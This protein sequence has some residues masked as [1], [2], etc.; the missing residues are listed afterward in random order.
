MVD[1]STVSV[2]ADVAAEFE[3]LND[4]RDVR[5]FE[6]GAVDFAD[7]GSDQLTGDGVASLELAFVLQLELPGN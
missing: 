3:P 2:E 5:A 1:E 7:G 4:I 6:V